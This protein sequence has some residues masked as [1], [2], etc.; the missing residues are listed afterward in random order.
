M[1][2]LRASKD[3]DH[4]GAI[5]GIGGYRPSR[6]VGNAELS[7][8][9]GFTE[10]WIERNSGILER[11]YAG[12]K[13]TLAMMAA[14][15]ADNALVN[16]DIPA[17]EIDM[18]LLATMSNLVQ[19]PPL[20]VRVAHELGASRAAAIDLSG[21]CAGFCHGL[22]LAADA[23]R[24]AS[25][26]HVL[27]IG[28]ERMTDIVDPDDADIAF[29]FADGAG[30]AVIGPSA[31]PGLGPV[32]RRAS[33]ELG[34]ALRMSASWGEFAASPCPPGSPGSPGSPCPQGSPRPPG[35]PWMRM[36]G[37][38]VFRWTM[39]EVTPASRRALASAGVGLDELDVFVPHQ[40]NARMIDLMARRLSLTERTVVA[41]DVRFSGNT[42]AAS[43]P[44]A[45]DSLL[46]AGTVRKGAVALLMGYGAGL[47][48]AGQAAVLP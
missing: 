43:V 36:N 37:L 32:V 20:A 33:G 46:A 11:R 17:S 14:E 7:A 22:A 40:A 19:T 12:P 15:A 21:A 30:A 25:A 6:I 2:S 27:V 26:T 38:Q 1:I 29:I 4:Y 3:S 35:R 41:R 18:V 45:L 23:I 48:F 28:A 34:D 13:E 42:S 44:L 5:L 24:A 10:D 8:R 9:L 31:T 16:A 39:D 47:N